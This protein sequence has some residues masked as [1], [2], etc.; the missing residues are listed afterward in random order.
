MTR[1]VGAR[2]HFPGD[3][4]AGSA[5]DW[6]IGD[7]VYGRRHDSELDPK[8][9]AGQAITRSC[10]SRLGITVTT[11]GD[12][13]AHKRIGPIFITFKLKLSRIVEKD[14]SPAAGDRLAGRVFARNARP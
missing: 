1:Q 9:S 14:M 11:P 4:F 8:H 12:Q 3:V 2:Q 7:Y 13:I 5:M 10:S 6:F